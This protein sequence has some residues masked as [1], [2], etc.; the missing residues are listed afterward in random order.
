MDKAGIKGSL[1]GKS[2]F[3]ITTCV[4]ADITKKGTLLNK[5]GFLSVGSYNL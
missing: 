1:S 2:Y 4:I 5:V 3:H